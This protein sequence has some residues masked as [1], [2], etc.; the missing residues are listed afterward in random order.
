MITK[1]RQSGYRAFPPEI[2][3]P[4]NA[5]RISEED[6]SKLDKSRLEEAP[7]ACAGHLGT[8]IWYCGQK[9]YL[10]QVKSDVFVFSPCTVTP[11]FGM[12][13]IDGFFAQD[14]EA[15]VLNEELGFET[16]DALI[17]LFS[18]MEN[19]VSA[20]VD[21]KLEVDRPGINIRDNMIDDFFVIE[22][23]NDIRIRS[24]LQRKS[25][26]CKSRRCGRTVG[27]QLGEEGKDREG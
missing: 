25:G 12:D 2:N 15:Y 9:G 21:G 16:I 3:H 4:A 7:S 6:F 17:T 13:R 22:R 20:R 5:I 1:N 18:Q 27:A 8:V 11:R 24:V 23:G 14:I 19:V 10:V 26:S